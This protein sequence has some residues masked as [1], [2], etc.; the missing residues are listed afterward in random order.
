MNPDAAYDFKYVQI[1]MAEYD[2][3]FRS[4][5]EMYGA[6]YQLM[7]TGRHVH[8]AAYNARGEEPPSDVE[9]GDR[10]IKKPEIE[11]ALSAL[12]SGA[13][14]GTRKLARLWATTAELGVALAGKASET[15]SA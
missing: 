15:A 7:E 6:A 14:D 2:Q 12:G 10:K 11:S 4:S 3:F 1:G 13:S 9:N 8:L 5:A